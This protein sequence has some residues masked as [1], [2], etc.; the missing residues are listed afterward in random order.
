MSSLFDGVKISGKLS[1]QVNVILQLSFLIHMVPSVPITSKH[2]LDKRL[3]NE[4]TLICRI[5]LLIHQGK[6]R[7]IGGLGEKYE[8]QEKSLSQEETLTLS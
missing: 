8:S 3:G 2:P 4:E 5:I 6:R 1:I 7:P